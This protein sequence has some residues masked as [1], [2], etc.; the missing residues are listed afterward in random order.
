MV[1]FGKE[2]CGDLLAIRIRERDRK[3]FTML[4]VFPQAL[5]VTLLGHPSPQGPVQGS[6][7]SH[8]LGPTTFT[9][10]NLVGSAVRR[11]GLQ[12][13]S[14][15]YHQKTILQSIKINFES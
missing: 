4:A 14:R 9:Q 7:H 3:G 2:A 6:T 8:S 10:Q 5:P 12:Q 11:Q 15:C 1:G 13:R